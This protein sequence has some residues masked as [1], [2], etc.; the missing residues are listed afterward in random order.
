MRCEGCG[1]ISDW[2]GEDSDWRR[3]STVSTTR[4]MLECT[5]CGNHQR[6]R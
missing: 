1:Q 6:A 4:P 2:I 3:L 5:E